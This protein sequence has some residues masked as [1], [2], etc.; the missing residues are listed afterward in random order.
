MKQIKLKHTH[1][2]FASLWLVFISFWQQFSLHIRIHLWVLPELKHC[3]PCIFS[4]VPPLLYSSL[5]PFWL[6]YFCSCPQLWSFHLFV[7]FLFPQIVPKHYQHFL[8]VL[9]TTKYVDSFYFFPSINKR[10]RINYRKENE[11]EVTMGVGQWSK[12]IVLFCPLS[13]P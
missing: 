12:S 2:H 1:N 8:E 4:Q 13:I 3:I 5:F 11:K 7:R 6:A 9:G 10:R